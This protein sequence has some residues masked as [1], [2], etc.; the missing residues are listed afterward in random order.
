MK[1][2]LALLLAALLVFGCSASYPAKPPDSSK[3]GQE[4]GTGTI[5]IPKS[6]LNYTA[7][8]AITEGGA[9]EMKKTV[10]RSADRMRVDF[11]SAG[12]TLVSLYFLGGG[13]YSCSSLAGGY[14]CFEIDASP[15]GALEEFCPS[16]GPSAEEVEPVQIGTATGRCYLVPMDIRSK[17]KICCT[18]SGIMAY[19]E[20]NTSS[21]SRVEYLTELTYAVDAAAFALPATPQQAPPAQ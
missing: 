17:R 19:H 9:N 7:A 15:Q 3:Q 1:C 18:D 10:W 20:Q 2:T 16:P 21:G 4:T 8:Y 13:L 12:G 5:I 6:A 14:S 11:G